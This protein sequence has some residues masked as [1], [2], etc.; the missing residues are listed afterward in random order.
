MS[1]LLVLTLRMDSTHKQGALILLFA[2]SLNRVSVLRYIP[3]VACNTDAQNYYEEELSS[4][5]YQE[6]L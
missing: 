5:S 1:M 6:E 4:L 3:T 2:C